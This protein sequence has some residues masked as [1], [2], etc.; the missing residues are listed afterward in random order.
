MQNKSAVKTVTVKKCCVCG[1]DITAKKTTAKTCTEKCRAKLFRKTHKKRKGKCLFCKSKFEIK[2]SRKLFCNKRCAESYDRLQNY[3]KRNTLAQKFELL[4]KIG[5]IA[6]VKPPKGNRITYNVSGMKI[7]LHATDCG[8]QIAKSPEQICK[9]LELDEVIF[10]CK[11][12]DVN[13]YKFCKKIEIVRE[14]LTC[15]SYSIIES[16]IFEIW[17]THQSPSTSPEKPS[18]NENKSVPILTFEEG[19]IA[20][21]FWECSEKKKLVE[22]LDKYREFSRL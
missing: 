5:L 19:I 12:L 10:L 13:P 18:E 3:N 21:Q 7:Q 2:N 4:K 6:G 8:G 14:L 1:I 22:T 9:D 11:Y 17:Q 15:E 16:S 20:Y